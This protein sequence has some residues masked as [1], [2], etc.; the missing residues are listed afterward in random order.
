MSEPTTARTKAQVDA[1][2]AA[3][4]R[5][6][7]LEVAR[8]NLGD[9]R[10]P[11]VVETEAERRAREAEAAKAPVVAA[12][13]TPAAAPVTNDALENA[14]ESHVEA[15]RRTLHETAEKTP[16]SRIRP[17]D[18]T[19]ARLQMSLNRLEG[20]FIELEKKLLTWP[21]QDARIT[22]L[23]ELRSL[24]G[25]LVADF[26][27]LDRRAQAASP[28]E[29]AE[30]Q[31][32]TGA[33][34]KQILGEWRKL[35]HPTPGV[36]YFNREIQPKLFA[37]ANRFGELARDGV[38]LTTKTG[39]ELLTQGDQFIKDPEGF[40][41]GV[42]EN[43]AEAGKNFMDNLNPG[44]IAMGLIMLGGAYLT[45]SLFG[46]GPLKW[47]LLLLL[48]PAAMMIGTGKLGDNLN[49]WFSKIGGKDRDGAEQAQGVAINGPQQHPA[50]GQAQT[51]HPAVAHM[52]AMQGGYSPQLTQSAAQA[53]HPALHGGVTTDAFGQQ[54][55][56]QGAFPAPAAPAYA[57][58]APSSRTQF[59]VGSQGV[60]VRQGS[61]GYSFRP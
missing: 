60:Q 54:L 41:N 58:P 45:S 56:D 53:A 29:R 23:A 14:L 47:V 19:D 18:L 31:K 37:G 46:P 51:V 35:N 2:V 48:A 59:T 26:R 20:K 38:D 28:E 25:T 42:G 3:A 6:A 1:E 43:A 30:I 5:A 55:Y 44:K 11:Q 7:Q 39:K 9:P 50:M 8:E 36:D 15:S 33:T 13:A 52:Q 61:V 24:H 49:N 21:D 57:P 27:T 10:A 17:T 12:P 34:T 32:A 40:F 22:R 4:Q 16:E